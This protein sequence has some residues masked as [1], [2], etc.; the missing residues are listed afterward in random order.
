MEAGPVFEV[1][2]DERYEGIMRRYCLFAPADQAIP[3]D[4]EFTALGVDSLGL[5]G[6][7]VDCEEEFG[8]TMPMETVNDIDAATPAK[9]WATIRSLLDDERRL[10]A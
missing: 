7:L 8:V 4:L 9:F 6:V 3:A 1:G 2:W 10:P 5:L